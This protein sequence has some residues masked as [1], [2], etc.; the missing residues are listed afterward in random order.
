[1]RVIYRGD[2]DGIVSAAILMK[3]GLCDELVQ[4]HPNDMQAGKVDVQEGDIICNL[5]YHSNC[6]MWFD[7]HSSVIDS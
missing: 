5:P 6:G 3:V 4:V 7:H 1:M 2:L